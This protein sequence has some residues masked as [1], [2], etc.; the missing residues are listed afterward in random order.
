MTRLTT[1]LTA[2]LLSTVIAV[3]QDIRGGEISFTNVSSLTYSFD[4]YLYTQTSMGIL[5]TNILFGT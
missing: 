3:G 2:I 1:L 5:H 4:I